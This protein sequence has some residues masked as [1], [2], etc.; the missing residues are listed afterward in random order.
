MY[1]L[2]NALY[3]SQLITRKIPTEQI[4]RVTSLYS[5][6][7]LTVAI[8]TLIIGILSVVGS[9]NKVVKPLME[10]LITMFSAAIIAILYIRWDL[11]PVAFSEGLTLERAMIVV[12]IIPYYLVGGLYFY[13]IV[14]RWA[15]H[16]LYS[17]HNLS[18]SIT[19]PSSLFAPLKYIAFATSYFKL[20]IK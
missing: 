7:Q 19:I 9:L 13:S 20:F 8:L 2:N 16:E 17:D 10:V 4:V 14:R 6:L 15:G 18:I 12:L 1:H 11:A 5:K 3:S